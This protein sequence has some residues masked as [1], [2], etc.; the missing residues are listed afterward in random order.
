MRI[1]QHVTELLWISYIITAEN[2]QDKM[3][4]IINN[5]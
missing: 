1:N 4:Q 3:A 2:W 5:I